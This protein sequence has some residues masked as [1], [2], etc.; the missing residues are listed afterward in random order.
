MIKFLKYLRVQF[1][2]GVKLCPIII[3]F[4]LVLSLGMF[5]I[6]GNILSKSNTDE[7]NTKFNIGFVGDPDDELLSFGVAA[8][9]TFD[10]SSQYVNII[11][12]SEEDAISKLKENEINGYI[13]V[14]DG[15]LESLYYGKDVKVQY[16]ALDKPAQLSN[17]FI[18]EIS[19]LVTDIVV[20]SKNGMIAYSNYAFSTDLSRE[21]VY[22]RVEDIDIEYLS[23]VINRDEI[24]NIEEVDVDNNLSFT[25]YY[26]CAFVILLLML[27]G[28][29]CVNLVAKSD[30][31][32]ERSLYSK[33][34][35]C[36]LQIVAEYL[37]FFL[38]IFI[39]FLVIFT[40][41]SIA[42]ALNIFDVGL[43]FSGADYI[44]KALQLIPDVMLICA[45][46]FFVYQLT[47]NII[48]AV[49]LQTLTVVSL[50]YASGL[51]YPLSSLPRVVQNTSVFL[52]TGV[53]FEYF[54]QVMLD[55]INA[56]S[57]LAVFLYTAVLLI[58]SVMVRKIKLRGGRI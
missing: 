53:S 20:E 36:A 40:G 28:I 58:L 25:Q 8:V 30:L 35:N 24:L 56:Q 44:V 38:I 27:W 50:A 1:L 13:K 31:S 5:S 33:G 18:N 29:V 14:P 15:F 3:I 57:L 23:L 6:L 45:L 54:S 4:T 52:P 17:I 51:L 19:S 11:Q 32:L 9:S 48:S 10:S 55:D 42:T 39:N 7:T 43:D 41:L 2:R 34:F 46:A 12:L 37:P 22:E 26:L 47:S 49:V 16:I 21:E